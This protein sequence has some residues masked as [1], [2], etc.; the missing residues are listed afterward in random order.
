M[1]WTHCGNYRIQIKT[2]CGKTLTLENF[3]V[4]MIISMLMIFYKKVDFTEFC[5]CIIA[6]S[7]KCNALLTVCNDENILLIS[8]NIFLHSD[9]YFFFF[10]IL[11]DIS[12]LINQKKATIL[13]NKLKVN[14]RF[15]QP[16]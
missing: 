11:Q 3:F 8:R 10:F 7:T 16:G 6:I 1:K 15:G 4:E 2:Q 9:H 12:R 14:E 13:S 5:Q